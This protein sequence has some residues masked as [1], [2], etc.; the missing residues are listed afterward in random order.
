ML[1][2]RVYAYFLVLVCSVVLLSACS[3]RQLGY[4]Y[5]EQLISWQV[6]RYVT[7]DS[8]QR[9]MLRR[10]LDDFLQWHAEHE[11][12]EYLLA[13]HQ[14]YRNANRSSVLEE[15]INQ[16]AQ[17]M[18]DFWLS[19]RIGL[20]EPSIRMFSTFTDEQVDELF[21]NIEERRRERRDE[22]AAL[23]QEEVY[24]QRVKAME[25]QVRGSMGRANR[26]QS[27]LI[28]AWARDMESLGTMWI[29]YNDRWFA[30][31]RA[32]LDAR[33]DEEVFAQ[34]INLLWVE[35]EIFRDPEMADIID[36]NAEKTAKFLVQLHAS[37]TDRQ[38]ERL[39][40]NIDGYRKDIMGM[41][42]QRGALPR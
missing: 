38:R 37:M 27:A 2:S 20:V 24:Q 8:E 1:Q 16:H 31:F 23:T 7:L 15:D 5:A 41:M 13:L 19:A 9:S 42:R 3:S 6:S 33:H 14:M 18:V 36:A 11:M 10:E 35:P 30:A 12:P 32:A 28:E 22:S 39:M 40:R 17:Q 26:Q 25:E 29:E 4:R 34:Q 21:S